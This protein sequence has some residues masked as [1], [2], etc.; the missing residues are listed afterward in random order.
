MICPEAADDVPG[1]EFRCV[2]MKR[3]ISLFSDLVALVRIWLV[4]RSLRPAVVN[5]S[6]PKMAMLGGLAA[7]FARVPHRIYTLRGLRF[8][9][10][11]GARRW[12]L[13]A[14]ERIAA[15]CAHNVICISRSV[16]DTV[17][18]DRIVPSHK[19]TVLGERVSEGISLRPIAAAP[20]LDI[21]SS[22]RVIGFVGRLTATREFAT[23]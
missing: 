8:E 1:V 5:M 10:A 13:I 11:H 22:A 4:L 7:W 14:C 23:W 9:T 2:P 12:V 21:P 19:A 3:E 16:R 18:R 6:T 20:Q 15:A 17:V